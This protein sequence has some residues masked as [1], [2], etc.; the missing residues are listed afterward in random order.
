MKYFRT[1]H[2]IEH[3]MQE[4]KK[5]EASVCHHLSVIVSLCIYLFVPLSTS[6]FLFLTFPLFLSPT[7]SLYFYLSLSLHL[8]LSG[9]D[10]I[11]V[12]Y[13]SM[14]SVINLECSAV[15]A[16]VQYK[17]EALRLA[18]NSGYSVAVQVNLCMIINY[19]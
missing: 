18:I 15:Q 5:R 8:S 4:M 13:A 6:L 19:Y 3:T 14:V 7:L 11:P 12:M 1:S 17:R 16:Y 2:Q 9:P 10:V